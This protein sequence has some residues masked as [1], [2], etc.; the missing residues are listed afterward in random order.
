MAPNLKALFPGLK[1]ATSD[2]PDKKLPSSV[3]AF[4]EAPLPL[5]QPNL[6]AVHKQ[7]Q[8]V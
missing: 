3:A 5:L 6:P 7:T 2:S 1:L 8:T 4:A